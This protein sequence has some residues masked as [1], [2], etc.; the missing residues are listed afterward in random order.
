MTSEPCKFNDETT[1]LT[2]T[3]TRWGAHQADV[4][5]AIP[6][7]RENYIGKADP[8]WGKIL[9][10]ARQAY[11]DPNIH[12]DT[13]DNEVQ[14]H[15]VFG[16]GTKLPEDRTVVYHDVKPGA[17]AETAKNWIQNKD[18][19]VTEAG[20]G[21]DFAPVPGAK[22]FLPDYRKNAEGK[23]F[24]VDATGRQVGPLVPES[25]VPVGAKK[26]PDGAAPSPMPPGPGAPLESPKADPA[27]DMPELKYPSWAT[28]RDPDIPNQ[29]TRAVSSLYDMFGRGT[30][31]A[32]SSIPAFPFNTATADR[33]DSG[34]DHYEVVKKDFERFAAEF[35][36]AGKEFSAAVQRS[37]FVSQS[38]KDAIYHAISKFNETS[39]K[40]PEDK[41]DQLLEAET[42]L[43]Q[44]AKDEV[45]KAANSAQ[46]IP[47]NPATAASPAPN[48]SPAPGP[49]AADPLSGGGGSPLG[50]LGSALGGGSPLGGMNPLSALGGM[51]PLGGQGSPL[52]GG[53]ALSP[54]SSALKPLSQLAE[55][56]K[57]G[58]D[59]K[60]EKKPSIT[61]LNGADPLGSPPPGT[62]S[63]AAAATPAAGAAQP[64]QPGKPTAVPA[65]NTTGAKPTV[66]LPDGKVID[67]PGDPRAAAAAQNALDHASTGGDAAQKAYAGTGLDLPGDGKN[68]G[69]KVDPADMRPG[70]VLK[71]QDKT[72]IAV[73]PGLVADPHQPGV[74]HTLEEVLKDQKGFAG[75]FRPTEVDPTLSGHASAPPFT[76][77]APQPAAAPTPGEHPP[78]P[79]PPAATPAP[80]APSTVVAAPAPETVPLSGPAPAASPPGP[81][82]PAAA[83]PTVPQPAPPSPYELPHPPP[84]T[85]TTRQ[86]RVAAGQE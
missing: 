72:M 62:A 16:D 27:A 50:G 46:D 5:W 14:R 3:R 47:P 79:H 38:G 77:Q 64:G 61:P 60:D 35:Q 24:P 9:S 10:E 11:G 41:W 23:Y 1:W 84:A 34:I 15:L 83:S 31:P 33:K 43:L 12:F 85:R 55:A 69:A 53:G 81:Q 78:G 17:K 36:A 74:T 37:G 59:G 40:I 21:A 86:E 75:I 73:A 67:A 65:G 51:N 71:W 70:D 8:V 39:T 54:L 48:P 56:G 76:P 13:D 57:G 45:A 32:T 6:N 63:P 20:T 82:P 22:A 58:K 44:S 19:T 49:A 18:G 66:T 2:T 52:G 80:A 4:G 7:H 30:K 68:L 28:D 26:L 25:L 29:L 42:Q